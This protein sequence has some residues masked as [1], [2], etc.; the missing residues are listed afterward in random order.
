MISMLS[1]LTER[2]KTLLIILFAFTLY[3]PL[4]F[5]GYGTDCDSESVMKTAKRIAEN[6]RYIPSRLPGYFVHEFSTAILFKL[7][8]SFLSNVGTMFMSLLTIYFFIQIC[9]YHD[10]P[11]K[12]LLALFLI[13]HPLY[14]V[15]STCTIDYMWA[16]ALLFAGYM[17]LKKKNYVLA[18]ILTGLSV[19]TRLSSVVFVVAL[20]T[21]YVLAREPDK[22]KVIFSVI[23]SVMVGAVLYLPSFVYVGGNLKFLTY[24]MGQMNWFGRVA[25]F[26]YKNIYF[27]GLQTFVALLFTVPFIVRGFKQN[28]KDYKNILI[29]SL[30]IIAGFEAMYLKLPLEMT[31]LLPMLPFVLILLGICLKNNIKAIIFLLVVQFSYNFININV[32]RP[33]VPNFA[34]SATLGLW[35]EWGR[36]V[37]DI[38]NRLSMLN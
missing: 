22:D 9:Q 21:S 38:I 7:G 14:W 29:F 19:G 27:L 3:F 17:F 30:L 36:L 32:A 31:Y 2:K 4:T 33:D 25:R 34:T 10:I 6:D 12:Y 15:N 28:Y 23:I 8:G 20:L 1:T 13:L 37:T 35:L 5:L 26:V 24:D 18:G 16:L 11:H